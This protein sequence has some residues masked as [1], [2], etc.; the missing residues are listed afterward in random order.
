[1]TMTKM[2]RLKN[3]DIYFLLL[4]FILGLFLSG[5][6]LHGKDVYGQIV[7]AH[8]GYS[9]LKAEQKYLLEYLNRQAEIEANWKQH[10]NQKE[11]LALMMPEISSLPQTLRNLEDHLSNNPVKVNNIHVADLVYHEQYISVDLKIALSASPSNLKKSIKEFERL[12]YMIIFENLTWNNING[13]ESELDL[14]FKLIFFRQKEL[15]FSEDK[16]I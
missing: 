4:I 7:K 5:W 13:Y 16:V 9:D 10:S 11:Q 3:R 15:P 12:P 1:M 8:Q 6:H 2:F 14:H